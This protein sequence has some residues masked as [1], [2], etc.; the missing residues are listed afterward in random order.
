VVW[1][2]GTNKKHT[3]P[4]LV[5]PKNLPGQREKVLKGKKDRVIEPA[6]KILDS[7]E[8]GEYGGPGIPEGWTS[9]ASLSVGGENHN[10]LGNI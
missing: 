2:G 9:T 10:F 1:G 5:S 7:R 4:A 6:K 3:Q 8:K